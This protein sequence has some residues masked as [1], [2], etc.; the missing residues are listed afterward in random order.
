VRVTFLGVYWMLVLLMYLLP[1]LAHGTHHEGEWF[2]SYQDEQGTKCCGL[3]DCEQVPVSVIGPGTTVTW[4][5]GPTFETVLLD[6]A[7]W[8]VEIPKKAVHVSETPGTWVCSKRFR[9]TTEEPYSSDVCRK[10]SSG[11]EVFAGC[12]RCAFVSVGW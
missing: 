1:L 12:I 3:L 11:G 8:R 4:Q 6:I 2:D 9:M 5:M 10:V 7:G